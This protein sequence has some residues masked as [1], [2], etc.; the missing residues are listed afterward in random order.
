MLTQPRTWGWLFN[1]ITIYL[2]WNN[3]DEPPVAAVLEVTNT[4]WKERHHYAVPL[5]SQGPDTS[6]GAEFDKHLHVS[7]F[8]GMDYQYRL[9]L[10]QS[11]PPRNDPAR[12][13]LTRGDSTPRDR[14]TINLDVRH[15]A[16]DHELA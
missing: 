3:A 11:A 12:L 13:G 7:P 14:L 8:L 4:P 15:E 1:P 6:I 16:G 5:T 2:A 9:K 10:R